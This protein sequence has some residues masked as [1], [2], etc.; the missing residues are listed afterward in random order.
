MANYADYFLFGLP[1]SSLQPPP[2]CSVPLKTNLYALPQESPLT[3]ASSFIWPI[4]SNSRQSE[5][6]ESEVF[7]PAVSSL[8]HHHELAVYF[9]QGHASVRQASP[10]YAESGSQVFFFS[11]QDCNHSLR[12]PFP[13]NWSLLFDFPTHCPHICKP[14]LYET[15]LKFPNLN[16][17]FVSHLGP[18]DNY[19]S[20]LM[21][22]KSSVDRF[23]DFTKEAGYQFLLF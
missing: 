8:E 12:L 4:R 23:S 5:G 17:P 3:Y 20:T 6:R 15:F 22:C 1:D 13:E 14:S 9:I 21:D 7:I 2:S 11:L 16:L 18:N 19:D 10:H